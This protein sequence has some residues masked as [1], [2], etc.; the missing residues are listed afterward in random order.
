MLRHWKNHN[1]VNEP[2]ERFNR[3]ANDSDEW[4]WKYNSVVVFGGYWNN[5][6]Y[7]G[8]RC[9]TWNVFPSYSYSYVFAR[10]VCKGL[11]L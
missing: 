9:S 7:S 2:E 11:R 5:A 8:S 6:S 10:Y 4:E 1:R 3:I